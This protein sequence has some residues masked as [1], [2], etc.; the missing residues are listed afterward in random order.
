LEDLFLILRSFN[1]EASLALFF[2]FLRY[3]ILLR[4][5]ISWFPFTQDN[6]IGVFLRFVTDPIIVP[7][8]ELLG[9][10]NVFSAT[11][12]DFSPIFSIFFLMFL[13]ELLIYFIRNLGQI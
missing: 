11:V 2:A 10:S 4:V 7:V 6:P 12:I 8:K 3:S 1:I 13:E 9:K 5:L